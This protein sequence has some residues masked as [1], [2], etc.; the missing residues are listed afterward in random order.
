MSDGME[1]KMNQ[2]P[3]FWTAFWAG[4]AG[5]ASL[6]APPSPYWAYLGRYSI[7]SNFAQIGMALTLASAPFDGRRTTD[8]SDLAT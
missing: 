1:Q 3:I 2:R 8:A 5:P 7:A 6:Y 4:L